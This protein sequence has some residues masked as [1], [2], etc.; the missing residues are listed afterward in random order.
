MKSAV[1]VTGTWLGNLNIIT[2]C[3]L[4][5][6]IKRRTRSLSRSIK[7]DHHEHELARCAVAGQG[8]GTKHLGPSKIILAIE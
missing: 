6:G 2:Y 1:T 7:R 4:K 5:A 8:P 3:R